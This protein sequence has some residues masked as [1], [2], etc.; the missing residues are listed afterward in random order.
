MYRI[1]NILFNLYFFVLNLFYKIKHKLNAKSIN[2]IHINKI[3][4]INSDTN[5]ICGYAHEKD[6]DNLNY[7]LKYSLRVPI[8]SVLNNNKN[9]NY[10]VEFDYTR[11]GKNYLFNTPLNKSP[12]LFPIYDLDELKNKN[13]NKICEITSKS[14]SE[15]DE[16]EILSLL[17]KYGGPLNDFYITKKMVIPV[18]RMYSKKLGFFP[19]RNNTVILGDTFLNEYVMENQ[20]NI[21]IKNSLDIHKISTNIDSEKYIK[22]HFKK[23]EISGSSTIFGLIKWIFGKQKDI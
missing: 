18:E 3:Y 19:F 11:N 2:D 10:L 8:N 14:K 21:I 20:G 9:G 15:I 5:E 4:Y 7:R 13:P 22:S 17:E 6:I 12:L 16:D 23:F 1:L